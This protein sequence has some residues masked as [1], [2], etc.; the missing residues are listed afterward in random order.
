MD[1]WKDKKCKY[2]PNGIIEDLKRT[3]KGKRYQHEMNEVLERVAHKLTW[4]EVKD[5]Y[6]E[7]QEERWK[8]L[9]MNNLTKS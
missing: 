3:N 4:V 5:L 9:H 1:F 2:D 8:K 6:F 7:P